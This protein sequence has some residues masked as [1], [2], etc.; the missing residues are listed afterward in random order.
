MRTHSFDGSG[1]SRTLRTMTNLPWGPHGPVSPPNTVRPN[2][3]AP[4][5]PH[6]ILGGDA[7]AVSAT[8][9]GGGFFAMII[10]SLVLVALLWIPMVCLYPLTAAA[11]ALA[12]FGTFSLAV[13]S[14]PAD[15]GDVAALLGIVVGVVVVWMV[16]RVEYRLAQHLP[17]RLLRHVMRLLLLSIW[18][19]PIIQLGRGATAPIAT[20][21]YV[22]AMVTNPRALVAF[23]VR[24]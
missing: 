6:Q 1:S 10:F 13:R 24:P 15:G 14:L 18:V 11:G 2:P 12:G 9:G 19:I 22:L 4:G 17:V 5:L 7:A 20:T 16:Y 3:T 8:G 21:R 23:L